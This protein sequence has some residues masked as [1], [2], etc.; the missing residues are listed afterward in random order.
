M[1]EVTRPL[2]CDLSQKSLSVPRSRQTSRPGSG[3]PWAQGGSQRRGKASSASTFGHAATPGGSH[4]YCQLSPSLRRTNIVCILFFS[5][6]VQ[7]TSSFPYQKH[8]L[9]YGTS[10]NTTFPCSALS[11]RISQLFPQCNRPRSSR[12]MYNTTLQKL[13]CTKRYQSFNF[14]TAIKVLTNGLRALGQQ[15]APPRSHPRSRGLPVLCRLS[16]V[17]QR[18]PPCPT[19]SW[20]SYCRSVSKSGPKCS[21]AGYKA[22]HIPE[23]T[24]PRPCREELQEQE[25]FAFCQTSP[26]RYLQRTH[27]PREKGVLQV[28]YFPLKQWFTVLKPL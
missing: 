4:T 5:A 8:V 18:S 24:P 2:R 19:K 1:G 20:S 11:S 3:T 14:K 10:L 13:L 21:R 17:G 25:W 27:L 12:T 7:F 28:G 16:P 26:E 15:P 22:W 6:G 23:V 9:N